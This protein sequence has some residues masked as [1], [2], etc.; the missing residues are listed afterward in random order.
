MRVRRCPFLTFPQV[1]IDAHVPRRPRQTLVLSV[2][3][4]FFGLWVNVLFGQAK[5][6]Y[7]DGVLA[8]ASGPSHQEVFWLYISVDQA[9]GVNVLHPCNL[10]RK[11]RQGGKL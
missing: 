4:M 8:L 10:G 2:G 5:V 11:R 7:V 1:S 9:F 3:D 6:N